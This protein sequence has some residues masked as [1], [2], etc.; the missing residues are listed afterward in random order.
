MDK[1][2]QFNQQIR[3]FKLELQNLP[4]CLNELGAEIFLL[5]GALVYH[6]QPTESMKWLMTL[7]EYF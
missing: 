5:M 2:L 7:I 6:L 4:L 1:T 3:K